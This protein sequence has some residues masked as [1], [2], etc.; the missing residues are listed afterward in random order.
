MQ[1]KQKTKDF[2]QDIT[3]KRMV[4]IPKMKKAVDEEKQVKYQSMCTMSVFEQD[5][6]VRLS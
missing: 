2:E 6:Q 4:S 5:I 1:N 3:D